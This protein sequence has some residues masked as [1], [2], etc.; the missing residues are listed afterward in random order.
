MM[1]D[2]IPTRVRIPAVDLSRWAAVRAHI[3]N[4]LEA[5]PGIHRIAKPSD[6]RIMSEMLYIVASHYRLPD[7]HIHYLDT[8]SIGDD[9]KVAGLMAGYIDLGVRIE[10]LANRTFDVEDKK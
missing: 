8:P 10:A 3:K 4:H 5:R 6:S 2:P 7:P 1:A 9:E